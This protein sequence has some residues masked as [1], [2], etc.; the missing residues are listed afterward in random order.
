MNL[1]FT[2][3]IRMKNYKSVISLS[4]IT[5][6]IT[7]LIVSSSFSI[8]K[9]TW[10]AIGDSIT[11][12]NDHLDQTGNRVKMGYMSIVARK[13]PN[14]TY[15]NQGHNG[16]TSGRI[17]ENIE[18]LNII[19]ADVYTVFLGT[20]DWGAGRKVGAIEDYKNNTKNTTVF[21]SFRIIMNKLRE[22]N[23]QAKIILITP[24]QRT[25][26]VYIND[27]KNNMHGSY[28]D[29]FG[30]SLEQFAKAVIEIGRYEQVPVIDLFHNPE[31]SIEK[32]VKFKRL[33]DDS[34]GKY[35]N[36]SYPH[37]IQIPFNPETDQYPYPAESSKITYD[38]LHPS[39]KG[40]GLI[41]NKLVKYFNDLKL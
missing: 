11:F 41:A 21:S 36:Y 32:L 8:P 1:N 31:M 7:V 37:Y 15:V 14:I 9:I 6:L 24:M 39:D 22:L 4:R 27:M 17:A 38:G 18:K 33:K 3:L 13:I 26:F 2:K 10:V 30:Q 19:K 29:R 28:K 40:N 5:L 23:P 20:N 35:K 25:D 12:L 34:T 16:W